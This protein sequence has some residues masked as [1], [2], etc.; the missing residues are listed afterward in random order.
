VISN[1]KIL[2]VQIKKLKRVLPV[3]SREG[4]LLLPLQ[5]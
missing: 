1:A 4:A 5:A 2:E 3:S